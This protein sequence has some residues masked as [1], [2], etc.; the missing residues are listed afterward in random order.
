MRTIFL[1]SIFAFVQAANGQDF[2]KQVKKEVSDDKMQFNFESPY[3][4][5]KPPAIRVKRS[6][7]VNPE[8]DYDNFM[9][10][11][12]ITTGDV[13]NLYTKGSDGAVT[14]KVEKNLV[15]EFDDKSR[16][17]DDTVQIMHDFTEDRAEGIR[18][19]FY[20]LTE[21]N[22][23]DFMSKKIVKFSLGGYEKTVPA[24]SANAVMQYIKCI[25]TAK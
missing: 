1:L 19:L 14:E 6:M 13:D 4:M 7:N 8:Q 11:F 20:N 12:Q 9:I 5:Q 21:D 18:S 25:K 24:D 3:D 16:I 15:V 23:K 10:I 17:K 22:L 2:C